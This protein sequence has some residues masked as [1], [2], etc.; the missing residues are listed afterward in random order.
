MEV[1]TGYGDKGMTDLSHTK[2]VSKSDDRICLMGSVE[3]LMSHTVSN[4]K[5]CCIEGKSCQTGRYMHL[6]SCMHIITVNICTIKIYATD[7]DCF[8]CKCRCKLIMVDA[9]IR[10]NCMSQNIHTRICCNRRRNTA[11]KLRI[12]NCLIS[13]VLF[14]IFLT[15]ELM[16]CCCRILLNI[17]QISTNAAE[18]RK[19][20][21]R[22]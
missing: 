14:S 19:N 2:N 17:M 10:L 7:L 11:Y 9:D 21:F 8:L 5:T 12:Q 4:S 3:E 18:A 16:R 6:L 13:W 20:I 15:E 22:Q 1:Y